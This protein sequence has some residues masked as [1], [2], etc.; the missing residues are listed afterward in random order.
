[1]APPQR[2]LASIMFSDMVGYSALAQRNEMLAIEL[3]EEHR[4]LLRALFVQFGGREMDAVGDGFFVEFSSAVDAA[5]CA[6]AIQ[7]A[8]VERNATAETERQ[9]QVRIGLHLGDVVVEGDRVMGDGVNIAARIQTLAQPGEI[10]LSEDM[11]RQVQNKVGSPLENLGAQSLKNIST[12]MQVFRLRLPWQE[13]RPRLSAAPA[14]GKRRAL[15]GSGI[16]AVLIATAW[17]GISLTRTPKS[18]ATSALGSSLTLPKGPSIAVL[19]FENLGG[20]KEDDYFSDGITE[21]IITALSRFNDLFVIARNST[22]QFKGKAVDVR[23]VGKNLGVQYVIEGSVRRDQSRIRLTAQLL[24]ARTGAHLW[25]ESYD[26]ELTANGIFAIQDELTSKVVSKIGDPLKGMISQAGMSDASRKS[27]VALSAYECV[28]KAKA[29][30]VTFDPADHKISRDC[31]EEAAKTDPSY[32]DAW[33]WLALV[34]VDEH[35]FHYSPRPNSLERAVDVARRSIALDSSNQ[36]GNWF[37]ARALFFQREFDQ[38]LRQAEHAVGLNPNNTA[39]LAGASVYISYSGQWDRGKELNDRALAL[40]PNPPW[41]Y[42]APPFM[43]HFRSGDDQQA[44]TAALKMRAAAPGIYWSQVT[45]SAAYA[46]LGRLE[47]AKSSAAELL[48]L[49]PHYASSRA[50]EDFRMYNFSPQLT[51]RLIDGLRKAGLNIPDEESRP[52]SVR[53][54]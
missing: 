6:V 18:A 52:A 13:A 49:M 17:T 36:M 54:N 31:L 46:Q 22:F 27:N 14:R 16:A 33:A 39:V 26:R 30:F 40:N 35:L 19:P 8:L 42:Y 3:L 38:C 15:I 23:E 47:E 10:L 7:K 20:N 53:R 25:A 5:N 41:W 21:D 48:R 43:Y 12:P 1:M 50:R 45:A 32:A 51:A 24:D 28:L 29:Y 37:L 11:A 4:R 44:L 9:I 2:R 34:Y